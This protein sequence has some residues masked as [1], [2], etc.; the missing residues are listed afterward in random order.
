MSSSFLCL[1]RSI[2][3][4]NEIPSHQQHDGGRHG[5][6]VR[7]FF[8]R[9]THCQQKS[10]LR[11]FSNFPRCLDFKKDC[12]EVPNKQSPTDPTVITPIIE[13]KK[14]T[15]AGLLSIFSSGVLK[16]ALKQQPRPIIGIKTRP[17]ST[18]RFH[19]YINLY[20]CKTF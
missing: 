5:A 14:E 9:W 7:F 1:F 2:F 20:I 19:A 11:N 15:A 4:A 18:Y 3:G 8:L 6:Q 13:K 16:T 12:G 10:G 17:Q